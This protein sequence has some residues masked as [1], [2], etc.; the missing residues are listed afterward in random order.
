MTYF[1]QYTNQFKDTAKKKSS[2]HSLKK[3]KAGKDDYKWASVSRI[4]KKSS[5]KKKSS[6]NKKS[7]STKKKSVKKISLKQSI[8]NSQNRTCLEKSKSQPSIKT[9]PN[10][11]Q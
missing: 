2:T 10:C 7:H 5:S 9:K 8:I 4:A 11:S 6:S 1:N 3:R